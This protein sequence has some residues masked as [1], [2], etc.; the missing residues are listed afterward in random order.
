MSEMESGPLVREAI[1]EIV[2]RQLED[3]DP[4]ETVQT[5]KRL[6]AEGYSRQEARRLIGSVVL[7]ETNQMMKDHETFNLARFVE[8]LNRLPELPF[9]AYGLGP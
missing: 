7:T 4:Q 9:D 6:V 3:G 2:D 8:A 5:L 1:L